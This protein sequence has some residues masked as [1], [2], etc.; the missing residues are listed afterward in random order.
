MFLAYGLNKDD[1]FTHISEV[2]RGRTKL[3]CHFCDGLLTARKGRVK[4]HHFAHSDGTCNRKIYYDFFDITQ[5]A[6]PTEMN[7]F[8]Y[9]IQRLKELE[10]EREQ[11]NTEV[12]SLRS[13]IEK[14]NNII[15][16]TK[17][18]FEKISKP[19]KNGIRPKNRQQNYE[20]YQELLKFLA[21]KQIYYPE[22]ERVRHACFTSYQE[23][24]FGSYIM[25]HAYA[26]CTLWQYQDSS[27][28]PKALVDCFNI[29]KWYLPEKSKL[30]QLKK[31]VVAFEQE[32]ERFKRFALYFMEIKTND[33]VFHKIGVTGRTAKERMEEV[34]RDF[35]RL[36]GETQ[37]SLKYQV[38]GYA[39]LETF[40]KHK[41]HKFKMDL[42]NHTEYFQF[43]ES[44]LQEVV[45]DLNK[46]EEFRS[47]N[48]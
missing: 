7:L 10:V 11:L 16:D 3:V 31:D 20:V 12:E 13:K 4:A 33:A 5:E 25:P 41:H 28:V 2:P 15:I 44:V 34:K 30:I 45:T 42:K 18:L 17:S 24:R 29:L 6:F 37:I 43:P 19:Y 9:A 14:A 48:V 22:F 39:F 26:P 36:I 27:F 8:D 21:G 38:K 47:S 46:L 1:E 40:F 35:E 32:Y 23:L